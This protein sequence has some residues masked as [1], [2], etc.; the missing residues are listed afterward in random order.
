M[1]KLIYSLMFLLTL[2]TF[3]FAGGSQ[4]SKSSEDTKVEAPKEVKEIYCW[5]AFSDA[6]RSKWIQ[7]RADEFNATQSDFKVVVEAKGSYRDTLQAAVLADKQGA[8]PHIVQV[9]EVGSQLAF[10]TGI[11]KPIGEIGSFDTDDYIQPVL[12]YYTL[13][14]KVNSIPFNSS[15]PIL[16]INKDKLVEAGYDAD[17]VPETFSDVIELLETAKSKGVEGAKFSFC[18]HGWYFEQWMSEQGAE[19]VNNGN[20]RDARATETMLNSPAAMKI[21]EFVS[22]LASKDLYTYTGKFE[23]WDGNDAIFAEGKAL[24]HMTSTADLG[25]IAAACEGKFDMGVGFIP[26]PDGSERNGTVIGGASVWIAKN[27]PA[28]ELEAARDF[29]LYM[30]NTENMVSWHK[31]TGYYPVRNSSVEALK[32]EGWFDT[33][34]KQLVAFNQ[35]L[36]TKINK[37]TA[38]AV[39]GTLLDNR[40][41]IE[42][43]LQKII[44]GADV[45]ASLDEAKE[46]SDAKLDEY[47]AN[48]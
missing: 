24:L 43:A 17:Y 38:G 8:A 7:D 27:H 34:A 48:F 22:E 26:I 6:P 35:L 9:F 1:K 5:H 19:M 47:N 36:S 44:Q 15:S 21:G 45:K 40:T 31:L 32:E 25:N 16:Y 37:A 12:N 14:G 29:V 39:A 11:F 13:N 28:D 3:A 46:I 23:D 4:E 41:I 2:S 20:G 33:D 10:D 30:T 42:E 18:L